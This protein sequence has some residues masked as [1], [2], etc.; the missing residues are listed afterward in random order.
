M[1]ITAAE[2]VPEAKYRPF[3]KPFWKKEGLNNIHHEM[4][5][6]RKVWICNSRPRNPQNPHYANY[7]AKKRQFRCLMRKLQHE[8]ETEFYQ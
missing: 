4:T 7:K 8:C 1:T 2:T 3:L 6:A 5:A